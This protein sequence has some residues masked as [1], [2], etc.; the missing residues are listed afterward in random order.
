[1]DKSVEIIKKAR[2]FR[3]IKLH[4]VFIFPDISRVCSVGAE[5]QVIFLIFQ[6][7]AIQEDH[8]LHPG[9]QFHIRHVINTVH[10]IKRKGLIQNGINITI[11]KRIGPFRDIEM[12]RFGPLGTDTAED[13]QYGKQYYDHFFHNKLP[14]VSRF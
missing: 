9:F 4:V 1:M 14:T 5:H 2:F 8:Q 3:E 11:V 13:Q 12:F 10:K 6:P 7:F